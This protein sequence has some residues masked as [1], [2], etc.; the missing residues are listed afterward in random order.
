MPNLI[1]YVNLRVVP[2]TPRKSLLHKRPTL[3]KV[4]E[5]ELII[6]KCQRQSK[7]VTCHVSI[8]EVVFVALTPLRTDENFSVF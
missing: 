3:C 7:V 8:G 2:A 6:A 4:N 1:L 5:L